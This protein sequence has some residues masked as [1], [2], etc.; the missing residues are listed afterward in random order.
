[1]KLKLVLLSSAYWLQNENHMN[2]WF[3]SKKKKKKELSKLQIWMHFTWIQM[4]AFSGVYGIFYSDS[5]K[6]ERLWK[7]NFL[8]GGLNNNQ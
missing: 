1:M 5:L 8:G 2:V 3:V 6:R 7:D 4:Q